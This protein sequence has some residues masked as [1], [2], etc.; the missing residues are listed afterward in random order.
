MDQELPATST[1]ASPLETSLPMQ[2]TQ[3]EIASKNRD[4]WVPTWGTETGEP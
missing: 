2:L 4:F 3:Q 1:E